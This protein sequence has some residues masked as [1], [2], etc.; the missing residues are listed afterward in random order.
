MSLWRL[1]RPFMWEYRFTYALAVLTLLLTNVVAML[2]PWWVG[3]TVDALSERQLSAVQLAESVAFIVAMGLGLY[4][5][6]FL[7]RRLLFGT[8]YKLGFRLRSRFY[9]T[10]LTLSPQF[11]HRHSSGDLL[12]RATQD[13]DAVEMAA[14]EG[15]LSSV[16]GSLMLVSV[17]VSML[18][19]V[20]APLTLLAVLPFP[21]LAWLFY[22]TA[23]QVQQRFTVSLDQF[24][25]LSEHSQEA[26]SGIRTLKNHDLIDAEIASFAQQASATSEADYRVERAEARYDPIVFLTMGAAMLLTLAVGTLRYHSG[27][28]TIGSLTSFTLYLVELIWPMFAIG[29]CLNLLQRGEAGARRLNEVFDAQVDIKDSGTR[30]QLEGSEMSVSIAQFCYPDTQ[31]EVLKDI[32]LAIESGT[33]LGIVGATGSGKSTL[34]KL[35]VRQYEGD[36]VDI[37]LGGHALHDYRLDTLRS[38]F[39]YVPQNAFLFAATLADNL[40]LGKPDASTAE[41]N[42]ALERAAFSSDIGALP[43]GLKTMI[44]ER[45]VTVSGGQRQRIALARALLCDAPIL[46]LDD[47]LSAVDY[48]TERRLLHTLSQQ[49]GERTLVIVS[50][51]LSAVAHADHIVVLEQGRIVERGTHAQLLAQ[52][53]HYAAL[54][55]H[56]ATRRDDSGEGDQ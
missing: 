25:R 16:D 47:T 55:Q 56:Q 7:W 22:Q 33:T 4:L 29:W 34:L 49:H 36:G 28:I 14:G 45:G 54:W 24:S 17:L 18:I 2:L 20:D 19:V 27:A 11:F 5:T 21:L 30:E 31:R 3:R 53:G 23:R 1:L 35:L 40:R 51:R 37:T 41:L 26:L 46:L 50:H 42:E 9:A 6:R 15:F 43:E 10:L 38:A 13:S 48:A 8:A 32:D 44:G 39:A 12:A 52:S